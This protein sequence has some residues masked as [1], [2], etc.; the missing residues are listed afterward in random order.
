VRQAK[1]KTA[2]GYWTQQVNDKSG[3][4]GTL[5]NAVV[6]K[7]VDPPDPLPGQDPDQAL[8]TVLAGWIRGMGDK[9]EDEAIATFATGSTPYDGLLVGLNKPARTHFDWGADIKVKPGYPLGDSL[10]AI[11]RS[12]EYDQA[13]LCLKDK[14]KE[15]KW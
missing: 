4:S 11:K 8:T 5:G 3:N 14:T 15:G 6:V 7:L 13:V 2:S 10:I 9:P 12:A 1:C